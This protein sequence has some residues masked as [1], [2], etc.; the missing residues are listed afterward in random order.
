MAADHI[1]E[2]V[3]NVRGAEKD[4]TLGIL[5]ST[6]LR[7]TQR[8]RRTICATRAS[9]NP[10][11]VRISLASGSA[12]AATSTR[13][14]NVAKPGKLL[15]MTALQKVLAGYDLPVLH[16]CRDHSAAASHV[17]GTQALRHRALADPVSRT[18]IGDETTPSASSGAFTALIAAI[19]DGTGARDADHAG[20]TGK[21]GFQR[22]GCVWERPGWMLQE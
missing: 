21:G 20:A 5:I 13:G 19:D 1:G 2:D 18:F 22:D 3:A 10:A 4:A 15:A 11:A 7:P 12:W 8:R 17:Q 14:K 6:L 9:S 16:D